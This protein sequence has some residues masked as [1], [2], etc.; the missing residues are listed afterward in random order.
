MPKWQSLPQRLHLKVVSTGEVCWLF[1]RLTLSFHLTPAVASLPLCADCEL[2]PVSSGNGP[3]QGPPIRQHQCQGPSC[4]FYRQLSVR[5]GGGPDFS[6]LLQTRHTAGPWGSYRPESCGRVLASEGDVV[7]AECRCWAWQHVRGPHCLLCGPTV[8]CSESVSVCVSVWKVLIKPPFLPRAQSTWLAAIY[9][10]TGS[11]DSHL[12]VRRSVCR[13]PRPLWEPGKP[14]CSE[15][16][17]ESSPS[18][19]FGVHGEVVGH[20]WVEICEFLD[21]VQLI[22]IY[23][24]GRRASVSWLIVFDFFRLIVSLKSS[25]AWEKQSIRFLRCS[26]LWAVKAS[27]SA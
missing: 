26:P 23:G 10:D 11:V 7:V 19:D 4:L 8:W 14:W 6:C 9:E 18:T 13:V 24:D 16:L 5:V 21:H 27:S 17:D 15:L 25:Q 12:C 3:G 1:L 2:V 22:V 20:Y